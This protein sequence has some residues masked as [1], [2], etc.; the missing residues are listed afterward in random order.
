VIILGQKGI[1]RLIFD[2]DARL[3]LPQLMNQFEL[4]F[5]QT[6]LVLGQK[7]IFRLI[8]DIYARLKLPQSNPNKH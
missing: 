6:V 8:F 5:R 2:I 7:G 1:F 4:V 3:K